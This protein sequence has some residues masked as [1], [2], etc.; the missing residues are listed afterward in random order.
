MAHFLVLL[1]VNRRFFSPLVL[2]RVLLTLFP[3]PYP[4]GFSFMFP[5]FPYLPPKL[6]HFLII[7]LSSSI[8]LLLAGWIF[9]DLIMSCFVCVLLSR[10]LFSPPSFTSVFWFINLS[11]IF[12]FYCVAFHFSSR[13]SSDHPR[14][15]HFCL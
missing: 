12:C 10:Y 6:F 9:V 13:S 14:F 5:P 15:Y 11:Y 8:L 7:R 3:I 1:W 4:F 2:L